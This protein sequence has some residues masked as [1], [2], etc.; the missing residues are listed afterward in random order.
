MSTLRSWHN[1]AFSHEG[2]RGQEHE[3]QGEAERLWQQEDGFFWFA[4]VSNVYTYDELEVL[5][6]RFIDMHR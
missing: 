5:I 4:R 1:H 6:H 3:H 2:Q